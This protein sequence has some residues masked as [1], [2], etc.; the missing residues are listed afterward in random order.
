MR[1]ALRRLWLRLHRW[2]GLG[3]GLVLAVA[4]LTGA[5]LIVLKPLDQWLHPELFAATAPAAEAASLDRVRSAL[6]ARYGS[7]A[8]FTLRPPREAG[9]SLWVF[10]HGPWDGVAYVDPATAAILGQRGEHEGL[11]HFL[12]ELHS[13]LL[14]G[15]AGRPLMAVLA[16]SYFLLLAT[17]LVLWWPADW[18]R[19]WSLQFRG[20]L[21]RSLFDV[22]K[23]GGSLLGL[24]IAVSVLSGAYMAWRP[25]AALV[26]VLAGDTATKPPMVAASSAAAG[27]AS[28]DAMALQAQSLFPQG[29][30]GYI[31]LS[32]RPDAAIRFRLKLPDDPH[33]N[34]LTS[35]WFDPAT[36]RAL[37]ARRWNT[38]DAGAHATSYVYPLHTGAL[39][40][41]LHQAANALFGLTL[42][43]LGATGAWLWWRRR[44]GPAARSSRA[45]APGRGALNRR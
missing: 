6:M 41:P 43:G 30:I 20:G 40:G 33:P 1:P 7:D 28:L 32:G 44:R 24:L 12:F 16:L 25:L 14:L 3:L 13:A 2:I 29:R 36:G 27:P 15:D 5:S 34:G 4:A 26:T 17:G 18:R 19:A 39:G 42:F 31:Q 9:E 22:H 10:V 8:G 23:A 38:L 35:V 11:V 21:T 45:T 37:Q